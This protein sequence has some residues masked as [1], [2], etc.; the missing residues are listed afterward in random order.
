MVAMVHFDGFIMIY[1]Y[2]LWLWM[3]ILMVA[4]EVWCLDHPVLMKSK[5]AWKKGGVSTVM[6]CGNLVMAII[7]ENSSVPQVFWLAHI[8]FRAGPFEG[9]LG[10]GRPS[11]KA[12]D[13]LFHEPSNYEGPLSWKPLLILPRTSFL[14]GSWHRDH[15]AVVMDDRLRI[16]SKPWWPPY[17]TCHM[18]F[19]LRWISSQMCMQKL[20]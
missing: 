19:F 3:L 15:Y 4:M 16:V 17:R 5:K 10:L 7:C 9:I 11:Y 1:W 12:A 14:E 18:F 2:L 8:P 13:P 6:I 20:L